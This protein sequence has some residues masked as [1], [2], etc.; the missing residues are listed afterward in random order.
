MFEVFARVTHSHDALALQL[1]PCA[2]QLYRWLLR[3]KPAGRTQE[4]ELNEFSEWTGAGRKRSYSI[5][6]I[7]RSLV[8]LV[9]AGLVEVVRKYSSQIFKLVANHPQSDKNVAS[10]DENVQTGTKMSQIGASNPCSSVLS[11][12][13][14]VETANAPSTLPA[15]VNDQGLNNQEAENQR[16]GLDVGVLKGSDLNTRLTSSARDPKGDNF[17]AAGERCEILNQV[18]A[19]I[20]PIPSNPQIAAVV[21]NAALTTVQDAIALVKERKEGGR[22]KNPA[23]LLVDAI[24]GRW[25]PDQGADSV[26][27]EFNEWYREAYAAGLIE[28]C[29]CSDSQMTGLP[30]GSIGVRR[31]G[32]E[33]WE[34]WRAI[35]LSLPLSFKP[36]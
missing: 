5:R 12:R 14:R 11:Y 10:R 20:A 18:E 28:Y 36:S 33:V 21:L 6:H 23:G 3:R 22:V 1:T 13:E 9:K 31:R 8:E 17:S 32:S 34:D 35:A 26:M 30:P 29:T 27:T 16:R 24:R 7:Q 15:A 2:G 25:K 19:A 4:F